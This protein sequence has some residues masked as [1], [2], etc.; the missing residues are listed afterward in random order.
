MIIVDTGPVVAMG[1]KQDRD[2][3]RCTELLTSTI[4]PLAVP[5]PLLAEI[6][7]MLGTRGS[8]HA[9]ADFLRDIADGL[10]LLE[11]LSRTDVARAAELVE[12]YANLPLGTADACVVAIA[13][14][15]GVTRIA[16]LD[17]RH[18]AAVRP[19]HVE[20]FTLLPT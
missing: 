15:L 18:F 10:Y 11:S 6:G 3:D 13:E 5:E 4:E 12:R 2:H 17:I 19:R 14:R 20:A 8:V 1:N 16:T 7:Y 9:E